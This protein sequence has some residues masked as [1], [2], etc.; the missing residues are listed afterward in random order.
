MIGV[1]YIPKKNYS[2]NFNFYKVLVRFIKRVGVLHKYIFD[3]NV[4][5]MRKIIVAAMIFYVFSPLDLLPDPILGFGFID[6][7]FIAIYVITKISDELDKYI[8]SIENIKKNNKV[9]NINKD[10]VIDNVDYKIDDE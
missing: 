5:F 3:P 9:I 2:Y 6:D 8:N 7:A 10:K 1:V 4:S